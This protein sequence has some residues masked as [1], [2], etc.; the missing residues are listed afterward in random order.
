MSTIRTPELTLS[1][2]YHQGAG[3]PI[4]ELMAQALANPGLISLAAGFVDPVTLPVSA[5]AELTAGIFSEASMGRDALQY[6]TTTGRPALRQEL[7]DRFVAP[8]CG[9]DSRLSPENLVVTAGSNQLLHLVAESIID[10]GDIVLAAAP[11]YFVFLGTL[12]QLGARVVGVQADQDGM[13]PAALEQSLVDLESRGELARVKAI[14]LVSYFDNPAGSTLTAQRRQQV[15][16]LAQRFSRSQR[17]L[18]ISDEAYRP[19]RYDGPDLPTMS[20]LDPQ[21]EYVVAAGTFSKSFSPGIRVGWGVLP[22]P[23]AQAVNAQ[24]NNIDFGSPNFSQLLIQRA[25]TSGIF[26]DHLSQLIVAYRAKRDVML[27]ALERHMGSLA[28]VSWRRPHG[29][30][31]VW[32]TLPSSVSAAPH[33][34]ADPSLFRLAVDRGVLYVP[35]HYCF[36]TSDLDG[37]GTPVQE[38]TIRL[39]FGVETPERIEE[40]IR[41]LSACVRDCLP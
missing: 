40:G 8:D 16:Q 22:A 23:L 12:G 11:S 31:Y 36:P 32:L 15:L 28:G 14:Y 39:S 38:N 24:K 6:G 7:F 5:T 27:A 33:S 2:R 37:I 1:R 26:D 4:G 9:P 29:G 30:L 34:T 25:L 10:V 19:L 41:L 17:I 35:G 20:S 13:D 21:G 18:V 3:Q